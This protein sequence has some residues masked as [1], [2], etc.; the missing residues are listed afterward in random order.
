[1][2]KEVI[3]IQGDK[4]EIKKPVE[5]THY[6]NHSNGWEETGIK[7]SSYNRMV[8]LGRC[9]IDGD[10]FAAYEEGCISIFKGHLNSGRY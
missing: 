2:N 6:L 5:F 4:K 8:Y 7:P 9:D 1:M 10:M 3:R